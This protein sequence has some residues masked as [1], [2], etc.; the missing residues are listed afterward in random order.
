MIQNYRTELAES[1]QLGPKEWE[2]SC[3]DGQLPLDHLEDATVHFP[4][5]RYGQLDEI[6]K[7]FKQRVRW[8]EKQL[9]VDNAIRHRFS[10][11]TP[12]KTFVPQPVPSSKGSTVKLN[13][14][15]TIIYLTSVCHAVEGV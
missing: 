10:K 5:R 11:F 8:T 4:M 12:D 6:F 7:V 13:N 3:E 9:E 15:T 14:G 1:F 2:A